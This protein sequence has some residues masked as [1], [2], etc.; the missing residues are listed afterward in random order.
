MRKEKKMVGLKESVDK[1]ED[2]GKTTYSVAL[3]HLNLFQR[4]RD[5]SGNSFVQNPNAFHVD[6]QCVVTHFN[7]NFADK[8]LL[9]F[10]ADDADEVICLYSLM[11]LFSK[12]LFYQ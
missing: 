8:K 2:D 4:I 3:I 7:R 1:R 5:V 11:F 10:V 12:F 9:G 6:P